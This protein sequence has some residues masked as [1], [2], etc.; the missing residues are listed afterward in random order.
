[1]ELPVWTSTAILSP[2]AS[3]GGVL[4]AAYDWMNSSFLSASDWPDIRCFPDNYWLAHIASG[5]QAMYCDC[6]NG[7]KPS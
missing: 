1:V 6:W 5:N 2:D 7:Q 4:A 3:G